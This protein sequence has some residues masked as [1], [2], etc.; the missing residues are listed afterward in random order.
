LSRT[1]E[2][3][4]KAKVKKYLDTLG[5]YHYWPVPGGFG[6][7]TVDCLAC[8]PSFGAGRFVAIE[9]KAPGGRATQRQWQTLSQ[10]TDAK[11]MVCIGTGDEIIDFLSR[12]FG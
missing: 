3:V 12:R 1:P 9:V 5:A 10:V 7:Q 2:G 11:G 8:I 4:E 6:A